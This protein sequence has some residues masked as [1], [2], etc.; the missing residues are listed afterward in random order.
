MDID[1]CEDN[2]LDME[3]AKL[4]ASLPKKVGLV[5]AYRYL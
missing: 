2:F 3:P 5:E 4:K 1:P